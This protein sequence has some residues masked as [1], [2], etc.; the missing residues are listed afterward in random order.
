MRE[1]RLL[2]Q[3]VKIVDMHGNGWETILL[4]YALLQLNQSSGA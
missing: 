1:A 4:R 3:S 2:P